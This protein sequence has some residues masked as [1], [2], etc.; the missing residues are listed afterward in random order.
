MNLLDKAIGWISPEAGY[1]RE[2]ARQALDASRSYDGAQNGR[3]QSSFRIGEQSANATL[4][5]A[6]P[7]LRARSRELVR[8]TWLGSRAINVLASHIV[9]P[10]LT[11]RFDTGSKQIDKVVQKLWDDWVV[12]CDI[13]EETGFTGL[14]ALMV[15]AQLEGGDS[16]VRMLDRPL[17]EGRDVP[18]ALHVGEGDLIDESRDASSMLPQASRARLGVELGDHDQRLG[19]WLHR[20]IPGEPQRMPRSGLPQSV[21][22]PRAEVCHLYRRERPGQVRGVPLFAPVLMTGRD[23]ADL[24]DALVVKA[25]MEASIGLVVESNDAATSM[26]SAVKSA[27]EKAS[28]RIERIRPGMVHYL[29]IGEKVQ[30]F[31]PASNTAFEPVSRSTLMGFAVGVRL[32]YHQLTGDLSQANYSSLKAGL[33]DQRRQV[34]EDQWHMLVP[35]VIHRIVERFLDRAIM[36][37]RLQ[38]RPKGYRRHYIMP[39]FEPVDPKKDLEADILAVRAGRMSPQDFLGAWGRDWREVVAEYVEFFKEVDTGEMPLIFDIDAR[40]RSR[41]GQA[42]T[43]AASTAQEPANDDA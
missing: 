5:R 3:R 30:P 27:G 33:T 11:V 12:T 28:E 29:R 7:I 13:E 38:P 37:G 1:R 20:D 19:Y 43:D 25:R 18:L 23:F 31:V 16:I 9:T 14:L 15:R 32:T 6:L 4:T 24:M 42:I 8:N 26:G 36:A 35:Q 39:A 2:M 21:L 10:D 34:T 22:T 17:N 40:K 41:T